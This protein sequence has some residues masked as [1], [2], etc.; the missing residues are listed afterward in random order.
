MLNSLKI[1]NFLLIDSLLFEFN[2]GF[3]VITG[4]TGSGKSIIIDALLIIFGM[5][6]VDSGIIRSNQEKT[7]LEAS[8]TVHNKDT[9]VWLID[10]K[11]QD[12][13]NEH[14]LTCKRV[15]DINNKSKIFINE[16]LVNITKIKQLGAFILDIHTQHTSITL[17][18]PDVQ[19][20]LL[21]E[22]AGIINDVIVIG[23]LY[24]NYL[25]VNI[26]INNLISKNQQID[27]QKNEL[28]EMLQELLSLNIVDH[29]WDLLNNQ[30]KNFSNA[31]FIL[32]ELQLIGD[33]L[34]GG[35]TSIRKNINLIV[36]KL[37]KLD[38][39][40]PKI[41]VIAG[42][43]NTILIEINEAIHDIN[44][45]AN[46]IEDDP[47]KL[48]YIENRMTEIFNITKK[49]KI[50]P[51]DVLKVISDLKRQLEYSDTETNL[52]LLQKQLTQIENTYFE[53]ANNI[54]NQRSNAASSLSAKVTDVLRLL[55]INGE[56]IINLLK[57]DKKQ[58]Y[59]LESVEYFIKF[60]QGLKKQALNK[61][62]SGGELSRI[63]LALYLLLSINNP[64]EIIIFDEIDVGIGGKIAAIVGD[65]LY[66]L[67]L[68]KQIICITHQ[69]QTASFANSHVVV[70][71]YN[72]NN[73]TYLKL[74][75][76]KDFDERVMELA[77]MIGGMQIN[78]VTIKHAEDMLKQHNHKYN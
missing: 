74:S 23:Q 15:I 49:Y 52:L 60:N 17:L 51:Q 48:M 5:I 2:A 73:N 37:N 57:Q 53:I 58:A 36:N 20:K 38:G 32:Q 72:E 45:I 21:D 19:R 10:N 59:G 8:F 55:N 70:N 24:H 43:I 1:E 3:T 28:H 44:L 67:G 63:T 30:H 78:D 66:N 18:K 40:T 76:L 26:E 71:K 4:E 7:I 25:N 31:E 50:Q 33:L 65:M 11:L 69:A 13:H 47:Q 77:R 12:L 41:A 62:V 9:I 29:E 39:I 68:H 42:N 46:T 16:S 35:D 27:A 22:Y 61:A 75:H 64:P 34:D 14:R 56:F 54:S 6:K